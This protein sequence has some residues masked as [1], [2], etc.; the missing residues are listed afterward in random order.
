V[1]IAEPG[2]RLGRSGVATVATVDIMDAMET[3][4]TARFNGK[5]LKTSIHAAACSVASNTPRGWVCI[6][7]A[8]DTAAAAAQNFADAEDFAERGLP[9]P[10]ICK[11]AK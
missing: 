3:K 2:P 1:E 4:Y 8:G 9:L 5:T 7:V 6:P 10:T 11:C